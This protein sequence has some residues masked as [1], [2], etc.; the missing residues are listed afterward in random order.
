MSLKISFLGHAT[1]LIESNGVTLLTDPVLSNRIFWLKRQSPLPINPG[2]L[3]PLSAILISHAHYDHLDL[4]S[5]KYIPSRVPVIVPPELKKLVS[6]TLKNPVMELKTGETFSVAKDLTV[7]AFPVAHYGFR[8]LPFR[9]TKCNGYLINLNGHKIFFP[10]DT[11]YRSDFK[12]LTSE[13]I[14]MALMPIGCYQPEWFMKKRH[15][16]PAEA[17]QIFE[18]IEAKQMI[19]IH[20]GTFQLSTEPLN[21]PI[22]WLERLVAEKGIAKKVQILKPGESFQM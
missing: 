17:I 11:A 15:I 8:I 10:G 19:P 2:D 21:E 13:G 14:D 5:F 3:P 7:K 4:P 1:V 22:E 9:Y 18:E 20:W 6:K 12:E 16:S